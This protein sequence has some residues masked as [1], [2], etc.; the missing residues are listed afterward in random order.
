MKELMRVI[1][2]SALLGLMYG[3]ILYTVYDLARQVVQM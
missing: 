1:V 3:F 2:V